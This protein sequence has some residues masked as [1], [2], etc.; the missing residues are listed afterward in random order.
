MLGSGAHT[1]LINLFKMNSNKYHLDYLPSV[2]QALLTIMLENI[3]TKTN[4]FQ[5]FILLSFCAHVR[6]PMTTGADCLVPQFLFLVN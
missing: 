1:Q 2:T 3:Q 6:V 5:E 4:I